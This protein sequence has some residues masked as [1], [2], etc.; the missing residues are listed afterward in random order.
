MTRKLTS[1]LVLCII[2]LTLATHMIA[3]P[4]PGSRMGGVSVPVRPSGIYNW[5]PGRITV[6][7]FCAF[8]CDTWK[9]QSK[10]LAAVQNALTG[11]P[12][13]FITI[14]VDGRWSELGDGKIQGKVLADN[15]GTLSKSLG[16]N[17]IPYT[18]VV[19]SNGVISYASEG[20][21]RTSAV[22]QAVRKA[23]GKEP[24]I[25][26]GVVYLTFDDFPSK[27][28]NNEL[29]DLLRAQKVHATF[30]CISSRLGGCGGVDRRAFQEGH[31][32]Q[33]HAW[34]HDAANPQIERC[35]QAIGSLTGTKPSFY[36]LPGHSEC[37]RIGGSRFDAQVVNPYDYTRPGVK[38]LV[39][40]V[41]MAAKPGCI[42]QLHSGVSQTINALPEIIRSLRDRG[43]EFSVL[44]NPGLR[45]Q[46]RIR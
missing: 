9:E 18:V 25:K 11:L 5:K 8:W 1:A 37:L 39:R 16:I 23:I 2:M 24:T 28:L 6:F 20:I 26:S 27:E 44:E 3:A 33:V 15:G 17:R 19:D 30:F 10:R 46:Q 41:L 32:L 31:S 14:S 38:E 43:L 45:E 12:V 29:L 21:V 22:Q 36:R 42:I 40:R 13:D 34:D 35:V 4:M 7:S